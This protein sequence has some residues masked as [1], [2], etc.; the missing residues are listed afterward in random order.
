MGQYDEELRALQEKLLRKPHLEGLLNELYAQRQE[1]VSKK[2]ML[3]KI[4][5]REQADV[6]RLEGASLAAVFYTILGQKERRLSKEQAEAYAAAVKYETAAQE[7]EAVEAEIDRYQ[8]EKAS[9]SSCERR[10]QELLK[11]KQEA[12]KASGAQEAKEL[13][14]L[15]ERIAY[16][17]QQQQ[18]LQEAISTGESAHNTVCS[19]LRELDSAEGWGTWDLLGGGMLSDLA[20]HSHLDDAQSMVQTLQLQLRKFK[21]ELSDVTIS[22]DMQVNI[23]GFTRFADFFFDGVIA[24]WVVLSQI[25]DAQTQVRQTEQQIDRVL[26][27]LERL[28]TDTRREQE[29]L[30]R[31]LD[32]TVLHTTL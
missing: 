9:I 13:L 5:L 25:H 32:E 30:Q 29:L 12:L 7:L 10:Y 17:S 27:Q 16:L 8:S 11:Q 26:C 20:K 28:L 24:D 14:R 23:E 31:Q 6:D 19:I 21:T 1:L 18:E 2:A 4:R 3:N 15:E 22:A